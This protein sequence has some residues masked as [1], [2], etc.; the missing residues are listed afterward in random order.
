[1]A[2]PVMCVAVFTVGQ[3]AGTP[4]CPELE[5][6]FVPA[7]VPCS[8]EFLALLSFASGPVV[9]GTTALRSALP[10][11]AHS[12]ISELE[13]GTVRDVLPMI[14]VVAVRYSLANTVGAR[15]S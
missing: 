7:V 5:C 14:S 8:T 11:L 13:S 6:S 15:V 10:L 1:M 9:M 3:S 12:G 4:P 2:D